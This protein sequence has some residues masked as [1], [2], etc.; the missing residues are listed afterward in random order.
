[1]PDWLE[2]RLT[3][4]MVLLAVDMEGEKTKFRS[5]FLQCWEWGGRVGEK[6]LVRCIRGI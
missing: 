4:L 6:R 5:G 2:A 3:A 1:M